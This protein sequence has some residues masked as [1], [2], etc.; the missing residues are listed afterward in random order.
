Y[1]FPTLQNYLNQRELAAMDEAERDAYRNANYDE[2]QA[3]RESALKLGLDLQGG[4]HVTLEV[5]MDALL[6]ELADG[7]RDEVFDQALARAQQASRTSRESFVS[8]FVTAIEE[9]QPGTRLSRY[10]RSPDDGI[11]ARSENA[12]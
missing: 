8:L 3:D 7:R 5:G 2:L 1:L 6:G 10:F 12:E 11:T 4:M 9:L